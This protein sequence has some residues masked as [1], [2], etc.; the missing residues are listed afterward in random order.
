MFC[1][2]L[3]P[4]LHILKKP[5]TLYQAKKTDDT[6]SNIYLVE[7]FLL[8]WIKKDGYWESHQSPLPFPLLVIEMESI[9]LSI[10]WGQQTRRDFWHGN[11]FHD[12]SLPPECILILI[13]DSI[14]FLFLFKKKDWCSCISR[15]LSTF[16]YAVFPHQVF[17]FWTLWERE[18]VGWFGRMALKHV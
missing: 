4:W 15:K 17:F 6:Y 7:S 14:F 18:R 16:S 2:F 13:L 5:W 8:L 1:F 10:C 11:T 12:T 3:S 9:N